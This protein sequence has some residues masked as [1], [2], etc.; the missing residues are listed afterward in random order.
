MTNFPSTK[1]YK[2]LRQLTTIRIIF[3]GKTS[4]MVNLNK[5]Q[6]KE[7][8]EQL[9][10]GYRCYV[11]KETGNVQS[12]LN[13]DDW[14]TED[15]TNP[16]AD[17]I[18]ELEENWDK[19]FEV[20]GME[21]RDSFKVMADFA[22]SVDSVELRESLIKALNRKHP[23]QNFKW[24]VDNAGQYRQKW[25]DYKNKRYIEWVEDQLEAFNFPDGK[26]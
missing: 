2:T 8:A 14:L 15:E 17:V 1:T 20:E 22:E 12:V 6:I 10:C 23:F 16:W 24:V 21:S 4:S 13:Y 18:K 7:I 11:N 5:D 25:F 19:Y 9:D 26:E 3:T